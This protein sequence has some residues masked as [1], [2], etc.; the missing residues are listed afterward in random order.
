[1]L[2]PHFLFTQRF[3][4]DSSLTSHP[5]PQ[6]TPAVLPFLVLQADSTLYAETVGFPSRLTWGQNWKPEG[7]A[8]VPA[9]HSGG[10]VPL[11][12]VRRGQGRKGPRHR[13]LPWAATG[14]IFRP[15]PFN[16]A[17]TLRLHRDIHPRRADLTPCVARTRGASGGF[18][19]T[20]RR[21]RGSFPQNHI[22][23]LPAGLHPADQP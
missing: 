9:A 20:S 17:Y 13:A 2:W 21:L 12:R 16:L 1:M 11:G 6:G 22:H 19:D 18:Q 8:P 14:G 15:P 3:L 10:S 4:E 5:L 23:T 7:R